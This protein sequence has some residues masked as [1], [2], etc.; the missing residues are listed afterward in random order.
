MCTIEKASALV[1]AMLADGSEDELGCVVVD[2][3]HMIGDRLACT[4]LRVDMIGLHHTPSLE[5]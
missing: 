5:S 3:A 2:E 1:N 4:C